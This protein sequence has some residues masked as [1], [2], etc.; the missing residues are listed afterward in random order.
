M[1][2]VSREGNKFVRHVFCFN[3]QDNGGESVNLV[4][5]FANNGDNVMI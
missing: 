1:S 4:S 5:D 3:G 2:L